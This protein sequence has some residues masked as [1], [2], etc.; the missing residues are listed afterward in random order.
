MTKLFGMSPLNN[1]EAYEACYLQRSRIVRKMKQCLGGIRIFECLRHASRDARNKRTKLNQLV[2]AGFSGGVQ[3]RR[4]NDDDDD[5]RKA[6][7]LLYILP[8]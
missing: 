3:L 5:D 4:V 1:C 8:P 2:A 7:T 6:D